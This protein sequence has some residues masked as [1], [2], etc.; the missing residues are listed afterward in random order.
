[1]TKEEISGQIKSCLVDLYIAQQKYFESN[2]MYTNSIKALNITDKSSCKNVQISCEVAN[3][4][5]FVLVGKAKGEKWSLD[6]SKSLTQI[7]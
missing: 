1:M 3:K 7:Q 5:T 6:E 4:E 2:E